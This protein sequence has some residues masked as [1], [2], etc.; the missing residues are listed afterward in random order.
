[1]PLSPQVLPPV[2]WYLL[3]SLAPLHWVVH[4]MG[5]VGGVCY[6]PPI[7]IWRGSWTPT[8][9]MS[10]T[11]T[12]KTFDPIMVTSLAVVSIVALAPCIML[13]SITIS[14]LLTVKGCWLWF[15]VVPALPLTDVQFALSDLWYH[16]S[17]PTELISL[18]LPPKDHPLALTQPYWL[19]SWVNGTLSL[20]HH[21]GS[22]WNCTT[23]CKV[24]ERGDSLSVF[25]P[26]SHSTS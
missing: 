25:E 18:R 4:L 15:S 26:C 17:P 1:M 2:F 11:L 21:K 19:L 9:L 12:S 6:L 14:Y 5:Q 7:S 22:T 10:P 24:H 16:P 3:S 8:S 13:V 20:G 23:A